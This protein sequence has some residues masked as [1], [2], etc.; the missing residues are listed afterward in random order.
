MKLK[1]DILTLYNLAKTTLNKRVLSVYI[2]IC[3][4]TYIYIH[5]SFIEDNGELRI[6][7]F[8]LDLINVWYQDVK[9]ILINSVIVIFKIYNYRRFA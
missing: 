7:Y 5:I 3:T 1:S 6:C 2:N 4:S 8:S 9:L